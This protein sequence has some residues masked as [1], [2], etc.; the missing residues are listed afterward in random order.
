MNQGNRAWKFQST[1]GMK[2]YKDFLMDLLK[3]PGDRK[4]PR[5]ECLGF[6]PIQA[7]YGPPSRRHLQ[8]RDSTL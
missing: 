4:F 7:S 1:C 8:Y 6:P 2:H 5:E 3:A